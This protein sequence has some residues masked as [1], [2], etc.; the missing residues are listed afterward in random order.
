MSFAARY[1]EIFL[2]A[3]S[4]VIQL[5]SDDLLNSEAHAFKEVINTVIA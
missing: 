1:P 4:G 2:T 5:L 3:D